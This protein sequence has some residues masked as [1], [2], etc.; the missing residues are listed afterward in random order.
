MLR[1][2]TAGQIATLVISHAA[3]RNAMTRA[4]W[5][6]LPGVL[7]KLPAATRCLIVRG[8]GDHFCAGGDISE[9]PSFRFEPSSLRAFHED[10]VAPALEAL[11]ALDIPIIAMIAGHCTGG[12]LEIAA[13]A[14]IRIAGQGAS[15][16]APIAKL[17]MP[18]AQRELAIVL[19]AAGEATVREMLLEAKVLNAAEM[20]ARGFVQRVMP[21]GELEQEAHETAQR[22]AALSPQAARLNKQFFRQISDKHNRFTGIESARSAIESIVTDPYAY[23]ASKEH[24][25]GITAFLEKR[26]AQF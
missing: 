16:G 4:M 5:Q 25:E 20:K 3:R 21:G 13:C 17:G 7:Q 24:V 1:V 6:A 22:I 18:M 8:E 26:T 19:R 23:A 2:E 9:Y 15:F 10:D 12:G 11:L 14:D